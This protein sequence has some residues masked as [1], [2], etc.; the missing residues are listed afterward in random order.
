[1]SRVLLLTQSFQPH[2]VISWDRAV[3]MIYTDKAE[4][5]E[6][7]D[8]VLYRNGET[9]IHMPSVIRLLKAISGMKRAV[10]FSRVNVFTRDGFRCCYCG[11]PKKMGELNYD[12]VI[13]RHLGG[14]TVWENI[15]ASCY[16]CNGR[17]AN[18][19]PEQAGMKLLRRPH[20]PK[21]LPMVGPR[22]DPKEL[23]AA[24]AEYVKDFFQDSA[25][26]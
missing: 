2:K 23:P 21:S 22:F 1:M 17:K 15:V 10:K 7:T 19:T 3:T 4:V 8:E 11:S 24:W 12:H 14:K 5:V 6:T 20:K 9:V 25:V 18:R 13:P 16:P 26:A